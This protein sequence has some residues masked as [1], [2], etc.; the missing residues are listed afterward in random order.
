MNISDRT[1]PMSECTRKMSKM[2]FMNE[3]RDY[4]FQNIVFLIQRC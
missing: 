4:F 1:L 3:I 2:S